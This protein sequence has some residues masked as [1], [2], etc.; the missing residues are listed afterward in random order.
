MA[1]NLVQTKFAQVTTDVSLAPFAGMTTLLSVP[2]TVGSPG[3]LIIE[4]SFSIEAVV[5]AVEQNVTF[6]IRLDSDAATIKG[7]RETF[8][9]I[10]TTYHDGSISTRL[11]GVS[12]G[13]HTVVLQWQTDPSVTA[14][15]LASSFPQ[16]QHASLLVK[17][18]LQ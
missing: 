3:I 14:F 15:I 6:R 11:T 17:E 2:I 18:V 8:E 16:S 1:N 5:T 12:A 13:D 10:A 9:P 4:A 7:S